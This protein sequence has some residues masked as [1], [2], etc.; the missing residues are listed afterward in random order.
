MVAPFAGT[1]TSVDIF[2][3]ETVT[4][5]PV[6]TL[7]AESAFE[8][9]AR[10]PEIDIG[11]L[12]IGQT[13]RS[14]FDAVPDETLTG[15][16]EFISLKATE[17]DGVAYYEAIITME[18]TPIWLRSGLNADVDIVIAQ[19]ADVLRVPARYV[20]TTETESSIRTKR[21]DLIAT[22]TVDVLLEGNDGF[23]A[24]SGLSETDVIV[25]P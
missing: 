3:G 11:K 13:V 25:A 17:I 14:V 23:I 19:A 22:T 9:T 5:T 1:I 16:I 15:S 18:Q 8:L 10:I 2:P 24:I 21:G 7:L 6:V 4:A 20:T 12:A